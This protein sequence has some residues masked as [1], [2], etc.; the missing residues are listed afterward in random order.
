[1]FCFYE[2]IFFAILQQASNL[3]LSDQHQILI[4]HNQNWSTFCFL[5][6]NV[7]WESLQTGVKFDS[8]WL[9]SNFDQTELKFNHVLFLMNKYF[10]VWQF[11]KQ[12]SNLILA[13]QHQILIRQNQIWSMFCFWWTNYFWQFYKQAS[14]LILSDQNQILIRQN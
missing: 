8:L 14:N 7:I 11:Y 6:K 9:E 1:M 3:I 10:F 4:R 12:A 13:D 5:W 2:H